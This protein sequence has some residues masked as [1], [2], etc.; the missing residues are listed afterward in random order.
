MCKL[1]EFARS[2]KEYSEELRQYFVRDLNRIL[3]TR[4]RTPDN[5][6]IFSNL[7]NWAMIRFDFALFEPLAALPQPTAYFQ[8]IF[9]D[10]QKVRV[11]WQHDWIR[12]IGFLP[13]GNLLL[14]TKAVGR[15]RFR[16]D[17][18]WLL[19]FFLVEFKR[20]E[21]EVEIEPPKFT[22]RVDEVRK[23][24]FNLLTNSRAS[25]T[26]S[27]VFNHFAT[28]KSIIR[29]EALKQSAFYLEILRM[30]EEE[31]GRGEFE[32][33]SVTTFHFAP[34]PLMMKRSKELGYAQRFELQNAMSAFVEEHM[35]TFA[36]P[37]VPYQGP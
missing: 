8:P 14:Y 1:C 20:E 11:D 27:F 22:L 24:G 19:Y 31:K 25:H 26:F 29:A 17:V 6:S 4:Q 33:Y 9:V 37:V 34:H 36:R 18:E 28:D 2:N 35:R 7:P 30:S 3:L 12:A 21:V 32:R 10:G 16:P 5:P 15:E 13:N 23:E